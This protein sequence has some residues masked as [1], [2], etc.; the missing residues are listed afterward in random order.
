MEGSKENFNLIPT[1]KIAY[2]C[3][4][5][6]KFKLNGPKIRQDKKQELKET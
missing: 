3:P 4:K 6:F 1:L 2:F 5:N